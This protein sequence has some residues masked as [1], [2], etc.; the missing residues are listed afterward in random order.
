MEV[1]NRNGMARKPQRRPR[2]MP[3]KM[4]S[5]SGNDAGLPVIVPLDGD[6]CDE[7]QRSSAEY[8][9][10]VDVQVHHREASFGEED[11]VELA[12]RSERCSRNQ[13]HRLNVNH[14]SSRNSHHHVHPNHHQPHHYEHSSPNHHDHQRQQLRRPISRPSSSSSQIA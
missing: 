1:E 6:D 3:P 9:R 13:C 10:N 12:E 2:L 7:R 8:C 11:V 4:R 5:A 14:S